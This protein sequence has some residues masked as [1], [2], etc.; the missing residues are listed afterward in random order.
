MPSV[1]ER[2]Q[3]AGRAQRARFVIIVQTLVFDDADRLLLLRRSN[4]GF[5]DG[6]YSLPGGHRDRGES[7]VEAARRECVEE[8]CVTVEQIEPVVVMPYAGGVDFIFEATRWSGTPSI[9]EPDKCDALTF[10]AL[11]ALPEPTT[12]FVKA[13]LECRGNGVWYR[14]FE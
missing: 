8:A 10:A 12:R 7:V 3:R 14:E 1:L 11:D 2:G 9:G 4:T 6:W 13:A 5:M